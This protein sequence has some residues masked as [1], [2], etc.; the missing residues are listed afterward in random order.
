MNRTRTLCVLGALVALGATACGGD[1]SSA[2]RKAFGEPKVDASLAFV[3]AMS[4]H[5][6]EVRTASGYMTNAGEAMSDG[7]IELAINY[8]QLA[9]DAFGELHEL[10]LGFDGSESAIGQAAVDAFA[11]CED[12]NASSAEALEEMD[13]DLMGVAADQLRECGELAYA[14]ADLVGS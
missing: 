1:D 12:A 10:V 13:T 2:P 5:T 9:S 4:G 14:A 11:T 8:S 6:G 3:R 7:D